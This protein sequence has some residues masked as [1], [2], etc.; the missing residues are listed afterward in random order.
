MTP[1]PT[2]L[3]HRWYSLVRD[4]RATRQDFLRSLVKVFD[5]EMTK[6]SQVGLLGVAEN[7]RSPVDNPG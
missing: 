1:N 4:K 6:T 3:L 7:L 5:V 2:A